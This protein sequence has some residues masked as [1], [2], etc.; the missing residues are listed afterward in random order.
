MG[1][2]RDRDL[3][4]SHLPFIFP[5]SS[6][7][8]SRTYHSL[9]YLG[10]TVSVLSLDM[11]SNRTRTQCIAKVGQEVGLVVLKGVHTTGCGQ[12]S[13]QHLE[14]IGSGVHVVCESIHGASTLFSTTPST[15]AQEEYPALKEALLALPEATQHVVIASGIPVVWTSVRCGAFAG[16]I[17]QDAS[18][19]GTGKLHSHS[20]PSLADSQDGVYPAHD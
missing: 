19:I 20:C 6:S 10:P 18:I 12:D 7:L 14:T 15:T 1:I 5:L 11:R 16:S 13:Q 3:N 8:L 2:R 17:F 9:H 4:P